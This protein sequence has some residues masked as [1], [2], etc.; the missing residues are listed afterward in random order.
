MSDINERLEAVE[1]LTAL[2]RLE[3]IVHLIVTTL[4]LALLFTST[5][6]QIAKGQAGRVELTLMFGAS[7]L[8]TYSTGRL[9]VMW[10]QALEVI[11]GTRAKTKWTPLSKKKLT[12]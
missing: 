1:R 4:S 10:N 8:I 9:L 6:I 11:T 5:A 2:F 12:A 7:G 3:R